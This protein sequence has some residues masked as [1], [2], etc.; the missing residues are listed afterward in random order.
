MISVCIPT[1][2]G[3]KYIREQLASIL[4]QLAK[5]DE[6]IISDDSSTDATVKIIEN[7]KDDRIKILPNNLFRSPI[8]N[9]ENALKHAKGEYIFLSD[10][11]DIWMPDKVTI[12]LNALKKNDLCVCDCIIVDSCGAIIEKSFFAKQKSGRGFWK[13]FAKNTY[14]GCCMAFRRELLAYVLPFPQKIPMHDSWIGLNAELRGKVL[15]INERLIKYRRHGFNASQTA[16]AQGS[17]FSLKHK[18]YYR[19]VLFFLLFCRYFKLL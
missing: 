1:Y 14:I 18:L 9:L 19:I 2:N 7:F 13:N 16:N 15:F 5:N 17:N 6:V 12:M 11:D 3:E 8:F 10:Q 4:S